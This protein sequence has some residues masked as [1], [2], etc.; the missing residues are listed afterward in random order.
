MTILLDTDNK[1]VRSIS[2]G[3]FV[4]KSLNTRNFTGEI[5]ETKEG[6]HLEYEN[7]QLKAV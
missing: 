5:P 1:T 6:Q 7:G 3:G 4:D 2:S